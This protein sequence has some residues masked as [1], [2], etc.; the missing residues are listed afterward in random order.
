MCG[1]TP[2]S[3]SSSLVPIWRT[4]CH[5]GIILAEKIDILVRG[6][7]KS[8]R[9]RLVPL[10]SVIDTILREMPRSEGPLVSALG[11]FLHRRFGI[12]VPAAAWPANAV[13][14]HLRMRVAITAADGRELAAGRD[15]AL[16]RRPAA[17]GHIPAEVRARWEKTGLTRWDFGELPDVIDSLPEARS[18]WVLWLTA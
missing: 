1:G 8:I 2:A 3:E 15:P 6:L 5:L 9:R 13:P 10:A 7:P 11:E 12:D 17:P 16:L 18:A 4:D 14:D